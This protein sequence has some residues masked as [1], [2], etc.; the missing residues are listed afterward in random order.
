ML[1]N[2]RFSKGRIKLINMEN[3]SINTF[4]K[5]Q[6]K[7]KLIIV[8]ISTT[9]VQVLDF[10]KFY[11][12][13]EVIGFAVNSIYKKQSEFQGLPV[14]SLETLREE[15][16]C[17]D[18]KLF[19][20]VQWNHLNRD[21]RILYEYCKANGFEMA[22]I[23]SPKAIVRCPIDKDNLYIDDYVVIMNGVKL[24]NNC[25]FKASCI[26]GPNVILGD[27]CFLGIKSVI[28]GGCV[29]G[30]QSFVGLNATV[31]DCTQIGKKCLI[32]ACAI[33]KRNMIDFSKCA[34]SMS[35]INIKQYDEIEIEEKLVAAKNVR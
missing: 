11:N 18:Y 34:T 1:Q 26:C 28:G 10:V 19:V 27:H 20:A 21:R 32:G 25:Y 17:H 33:V 35:G 29:I 24:G 15:C 4:S 8:G 30:E 9:S 5:Q 16:P 14:Y 12:L 13:Y 22:N 2:G 3:K 31:F 23:I 6:S 7:E